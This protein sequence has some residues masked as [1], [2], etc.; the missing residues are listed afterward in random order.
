MKM[1]T[2][3]QCTIIGMNN[4]KT[5]LK[6]MILIFLC[7]AIGMGIRVFLLLSGKAPVADSLHFFELSAI[8]EK[9]VTPVMTSGIAFAYS[10]SLTNIFKFT[11]NRLAAAAWYHIL[12][13]AIAFFFLF[14]GCRLLFGKTAALFESVVYAVAPWLIKGIFVVSPESFYLFWWSLLFLLVGIFAKK[15]REKGWYRKNA[16]EIY[17]MLMGFLTG[18][19]CI[20][21][22]AGFLLLLFLAYAIFRNMSVIL[23]KRSIWKKTSFMESLLEEE[24]EA[25]G[26]KRERMPF[27]SEVLILAAGMS[28]GG[29]VTL[30]KYTGVTGLYLREQFRLWKEQLFRFENDRLQDLAPGFFPGIL[31]AVCAGALAEFFLKT[32]AERK[33]EG[34]DTEKEETQELKKQE[35][36][37]EEK[38]VQEGQQVK[39]LDNPLPLPKKHVKRELEFA[40]D[41]ED[42]FDIE[43]EKGDDFDI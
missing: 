38:E 28:L 13:Q 5:L 29:Y 37:K 15:T 21:H 6:E 43:I 26:K 1:M 7:F 8:Q 30:M 24:D 35:P 36:K 25:E 34:K 23:E 33:A 16:D 12:L 18:I 20:W 41:K 32:A 19:I 31:I 3:R 39:Y 42:D 10:E 9:Q 40:L 22:C 2:Y 11:G 27:S 4:K 14:F 17:L